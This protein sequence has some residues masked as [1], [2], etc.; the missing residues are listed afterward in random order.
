MYSGGTYTLDYMALAKSLEGPANTYCRFTLSWKVANLN[1]QS[2]LGHIK[3]LRSGLSNDFL[4]NQVEL[5]PLAIHIFRNL[6][7]LRKRDGT[8]A[9][10][11]PNNPIK[12]SNAGSICRESPDLPRYPP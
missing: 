5:S 2:G 7:R 10:T 9:R 1:K 8:K 3:N 11:R 6:M 12:F 4:D